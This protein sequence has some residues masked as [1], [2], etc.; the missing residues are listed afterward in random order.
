VQTAS[1]DKVYGEEARSDTWLRT[2]REVYGDDYP[3]EVEPA[4]FVT[5]TDLAR[6]AER[7]SLGPGQTLVDLGC[8]RGGPGL[9]LAR[10]MRSDLVGIDLSGEA[11]RQAK[12][13]GAVFGL[14][15]RARFIVAD[16]CAT[17]LEDESCDGAVCIDMLDHVSRRVAALRETARIV[18]PGARLILTRWE[19]TRPEELNSRQLLRRAGWAVEEVTEKPAWRS[20]QQAV[21][22][23]ALAEQSELVKELDESVARILIQEARDFRAWSAVRRHVFVV[24]TRA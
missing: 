6:M 8:G 13:R 18:R 19:S 12:E 15:G 9:W 3:E 23:R 4:S 20:R 11:I 16:I 21:Y 17:T 22:D 14:Q 10:E 1:Y 2:M 7:F 24:A 5:R